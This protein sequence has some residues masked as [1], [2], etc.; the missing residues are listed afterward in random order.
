[1]AVV[2]GEIF[3]LRTVALYL[4]DTAI[5][6]RS[7]AQNNPGWIDDYARLC[8]ILNDWYQKLSEDDDVE[9]LNPHNWR[10]L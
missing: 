1:M 5:K 10:P 6:L 2:T 3:D 9:G 8:L 7:Y 4:Q